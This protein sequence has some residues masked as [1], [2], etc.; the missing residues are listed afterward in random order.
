MVSLFSYRIIVCL[1]KRHQRQPSGSRKIIVSKPKS[2]LDHIRRYSMPV[3]RMRQ[4][5][6]S[7]ILMMKEVRTEKKIIWF[8]GNSLSLVILLRL[9]RK[10]LFFLIAVSFP[11]FPI[12]HLC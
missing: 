4:G 8:T 2:R 7:N 5:A 11:K 1:L 3:I 10:L 12:L 6:D 9:R